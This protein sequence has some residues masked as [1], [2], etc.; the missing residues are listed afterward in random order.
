MNETLSQPASPQSGRRTRARHRV[1]SSARRRH[2]PILHRFA[3]RML[4]EPQTPR[5][6]CRK[7][8]CGSGAK[9]TATIS[10]AR[11]SPPAASLRPQRVHRSASAPWTTYARGR[12][13]SRRRG[14]PRP[15]RRSR[16][17][18]A[19]CS[20]HFP[21]ASAQ[22]CCSVI[23]NAC[24]S[25]GC[26][27]DTSAC[28]A[29][30]PSCARSAP[31]RADLVNAATSTRACRMKREEVEHFLDLHGAQS[32]LWPENAR[33]VVFGPRQSTQ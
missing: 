9:R 3:L 22:R 32:N 18:R 4:G 29:S 5:T 19:G 1:H 17:H 10:H 8:C 15:G 12:G 28:T 20:R 13:H 14:D 25:R 33:D 16:A 27:R 24:H 2:A 21:S 7:R 31:L 6:W 26:G 30:S 11:A 23:I